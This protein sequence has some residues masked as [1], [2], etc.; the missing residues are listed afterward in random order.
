MKTIMMVTHSSNLTGGGESDFLVLLKH[1]RKNNHIVSVYPT[2]PSSEI[3]K[4][5]SDE[6]IEIPDRI[7][8]FTYFNIKDYLLYIYYS[9]KKALLLI[10]YLNN[11]RNK[12]DICFVN[13]SV[14]LAE[15]V[16]LILLRI[17]YII[18]IK[19]MTDPFWVRFIIYKLINKSAKK[20]I[21]VSKTL[22]LQFIEINKDAKPVVIRSAI[23][24]KLFKS[25]K[26]ELTENQTRKTDEFLI[27]NIA[28]ITKN[29]N[30]IFLINS[31]KKCKALRKI[32]IVFIGSVVDKQYYELLLNTIKEIE[33][34]NIEFVFV[35]ELSKSEIIR[36]LF[37]SDCVVITSKREGMPVVLAEALFM[38]KPIITTNVGMVQEFIV[39]GT[40]GFIIDEGNT[41]LFASII[42]KL[43]TDDAFLQSFKYKLNDTYSSGFS[44]EYYLSKH[45]ECL[46][47]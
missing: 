22:K 38:E 30:Q 44:C 10:P 19:E 16:I 42:D 5:F 31:I 3:I 9:I 29:K 34:S 46:L 21:V 7:F 24:E 14:C 8:P 36:Y 20:V 1:L 41:D 40:N 25:L 11:V 26:L 12:I 23:D 15:I 2:G 6:S 43:A 39:N 37:V 13:S 4:S 18:S 28:S 45:E 47:N 33:A 32:K 17:P 35:G 27:I